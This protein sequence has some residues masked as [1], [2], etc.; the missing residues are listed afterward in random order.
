MRNF[1]YIAAT[2]TWQWPIR[3]TRS[4]SH[5]V[6]EQAKGALMLD[7]GLDADAA[8]ALLSWQP[9]SQNIKLRDLPQ[10][11][12]AA[13]PGD[14]TVPTSP[15]SASGP[16]S[17][18]AWYSA[19]RVNMLDALVTAGACG[20]LIRVKRQDISTIAQL[21]GMITAQLSQCTRCLM[22]DVSGLQ[23]ADS[24]S[25]WVLLLVARTLKTQGG[26]M[27]LIQPQPAVA[28]MLTLVITQTR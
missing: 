19:R 23:F 18:T 27:V 15:S 21:T 14:A 26:S 5:A 7:Y 25:I 17:F 13:P 4:A 11:L 20:P 16:R 24:M 28:R 8:I 1:Y 12:A 9:Q 22:I 6:I 10:R 3:P 2:D